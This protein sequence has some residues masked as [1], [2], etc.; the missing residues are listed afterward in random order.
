M[1]P[2]R[3]RTHADVSCSQQEPRLMGLV[4]ARLMGLVAAGSKTIL[5]PFYSLNKNQ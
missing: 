3:D 2:A 4:A 5:D 1:G